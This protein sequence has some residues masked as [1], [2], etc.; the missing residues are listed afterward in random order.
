MNHGPYGLEARGCLI[1]AKVD[2]YLH[3]YQF[4]PPYQDTHLLER[5]LTEEAC[6]TPNVA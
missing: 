3:I 5:C 1:M 4:S 2:R 6:N